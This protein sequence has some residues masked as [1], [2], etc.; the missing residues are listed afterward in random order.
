MISAL[1]GDGVADVKRWLAA[2]VPRR[3]LA[4]SRGPAHR[5]AAAPARG[6]DHAREALSA[7]ARG[8]A[9]PVD[10]RDR[11]VEGAQGR[12]DPHRADDLRG[13]REPAQDRARQGRPDHQGDRR[14][15]AARD[16]SRSSRCR[17]T[18]SCSSRCAR[19][20]RRPGALPRDGA[21]VPAPEVSHQKVAP[22]PGSCRP[23]APPSVREVRCFGEIV[24][25][26]HLSLCGSSLASRRV[27]GLPF[28]APGLACNG[29][30]KA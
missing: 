17:C 13:A 24:A 1:T 26:D 14:G 2:H 27:S 21:G 5:R 4:L 15:S 9:L 10:G 22:F 16:R 29:P 23:T 19:L 30:M 3:P 25:S 28:G 7:P 20:G 6:R 11:E 18:C 8:A 12:L